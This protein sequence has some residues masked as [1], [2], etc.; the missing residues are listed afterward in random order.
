MRCRAIYYTDRRGEA[1]ARSF[2]N[3]L[4]KKHRAK[5]KRWIGELQELG[6][7]LP[8]PYADT[9]AGKIREL[10]VDFGGYRYRILYFF[11]GKDI[12]LAHTFLKKTG[13]VPKGEI[14]R[15]QRRMAHWS[16]K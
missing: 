7:D 9:L 10:R 11:D 15:A 8:R 4:P 3:A 13:P 14:E 12:V 6:P 2:I 5:I 1:P 16:V